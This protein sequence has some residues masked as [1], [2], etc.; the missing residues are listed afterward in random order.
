MRLRPKPER[1]QSPAVARILGVTTKT[2]QDMAARGELPSAARIGHRWTFNEAK[3]R[4]FVKARE[5]DCQ[6]RAPRASAFIGR[7]A[8]DLRLPDATLDAA[9]EEAIGLNRPGVIRYRQR[10][11]KKRRQD[12]GK[13]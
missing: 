3:I 6:Q 9:Y 1:I 13:D 10:M 4:E 8:V 5:D 11:E 2:V 7:A 12:E